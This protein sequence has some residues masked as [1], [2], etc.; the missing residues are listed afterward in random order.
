MQ[1]FP[2]RQPF[3]STRPRGA[4]L[5]YISRQLKLMAF[6]STRPRGARLFPSGPVYRLCLYFNPRARVGRD[7]LGSPCVQVISD[8]NPRARVGRDDLKNS[9]R[10]LRDAFQSTRPRGARL[11]LALA[12]GEDLAFQ[13]TRPRGARRNASMEDSITITFQSTRPRGA[14]R[15][16]VTLF[17]S[18]SDFNPRARM[19]ARPLSQSNHPLISLFQSTRPHGGATRRGGRRGMAHQISIHAPAWGRD[20]TVQEYERQDVY[21][22]PRA[23]MGARRCSGSAD[24]ASA[25]FQST[26]PHGGAT[27]RDL[28]HDNQVS[29]SIHAPAWGRDGRMVVTGVRHA[30]SIHAPAWGRDMGVLVWYTSSIISIH[31][32]AWGRDP[33]QQRCGLHMH[34]FNPRARMGARH[35]IWFDH[36]EILDFNPRARMGARLTRSARALR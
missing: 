1:I 22:N 16:R 19:G 29:I 13:S 24:S 9:L 4:R 30:I 8:F 21:F 7:K 35:P 23:R 32:P 11:N 2:L 12:S 17:D 10:K 15:E 3:Q 28:A 33:A 25:I 36:I 26:R 20:F 31:A 6:Q 5:S 14:R 27:S 18:K 34:H